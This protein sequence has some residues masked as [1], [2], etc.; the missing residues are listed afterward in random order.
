MRIRG[1]VH[2]VTDFIDEHPGAQLLLLSS[3]GRDATEA[4]DYV[5]HSRHADRLL[6]TMAVPQLDRCAAISLQM[7]REESAR[8]EQGG[9]SWSSTWL[10]AWRQQTLSATVRITVRDAIESTLI[11]LTGDTGPTSMRRVQV[12]S[13]LK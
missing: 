9:R 3:V 13:F 10:E 4:Y 11:R 6:A 1:H 12:M 2:D 7:S 5:D 8:E